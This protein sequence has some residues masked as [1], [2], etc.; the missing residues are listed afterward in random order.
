MTT[1]QKELPAGW[2]WVKLGDV[3]EV[4]PRRPSALNAAEDK[5]TTFVPMTC[6]DENSRGISRLENRPF[7]QV[8]KGYTYF[9]E[10]DVI[11]AKITPCMENGKHAIARGLQDGFGFGSTEFHVIRVGNESISDWIHQY[12]TLPSKLREAKAHFKGTAGQKRVPKEFLHSLPIPLPPLEEQKRIAGILNKAEE[13]K[14]LREEADKKTEELIPAIFHEMF[15]DT[16]RNPK[17]WNVETIGNL[18]EK[19]GS[20][21][22]PKGGKSVYVDDGPLFIRSQNVQM[23]QLDLSD[24]ARIPWDI[25]ESMSSTKVFPGD[26]LLNITGASIGRVTWVPHLDEEAN[27]NQH[28]CIIRLKPDKALPEFEVDPVFRTTG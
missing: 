15:G 14:K 28:V 13:I 9:E 1:G 8:S 23:N 11:Y 3:C 24:V 6:V 26:V 20:G 2:K 27:V 19:V 22:T 25:H 16:G 5:P 18:S 17:N 7:A 12:I 10:N 21:I 4:N